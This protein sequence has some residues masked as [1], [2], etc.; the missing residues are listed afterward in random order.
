MREL[1]DEFGI[2]V[3]LITHDLGVVAEVADDVA[4]MYLGKVIERQMS[5]TSS[6][7]RSIRTRRRCSARFRASTRPARRAPGPDPRHGAEPVRPPRRLLLHPRCPNVPARCLRPVIPEPDAAPLGQSRALL[8]TRSC[9]RRILG[10]HERSKRWSR[11]DA[12]SLIPDMKTPRRC[13]EVARPQDPLPGQKGGCFD[14]SRGLSR[15]STA[16]SSA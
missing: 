7:R 12:C 4:V 5:S 11:P 13:L 14:A 15:R 3:M 1:Q 16:S 9:P 10:E 6:M 2:A 8:A